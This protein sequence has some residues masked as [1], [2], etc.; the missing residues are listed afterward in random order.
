VLPP[1]TAENLIG[2]GV[3]A[4]LLALLSPLPTALSVVLYVDQRVRTEGFDIE[5]M[6]RGAGLMDGP[7]VEEHTAPAEDSDGVSPEKASGDRV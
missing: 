1:S 6:A 4:L 7:G 5:W 2:G 3:I